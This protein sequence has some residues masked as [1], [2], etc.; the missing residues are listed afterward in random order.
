VTSRTDS[1]RSRRIPDDRGFLIIAGVQGHEHIGSRTKGLNDLAVKDH[2]RQTTKDPSVIL[3][4]F[5]NFSS[6]TIKS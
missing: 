1:A 4:E 5:N 2:Y 6:H 3:I